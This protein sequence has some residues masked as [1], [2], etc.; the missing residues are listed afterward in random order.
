M[1]PDL[2]CDDVF[3]IETKR[4]WLRWPTLADMPAILRLAGEKQIAEMT[5]RIPHPYPPHEAESYIRAARA[6]NQ[7][8]NSL[9]MA[10][11]L[12]EKPDELLGMIGLSPARGA[13]PVLGYWIGRPYWGCGYATEAAQAMIDTAFTLAD[14]GSIAAAA[15]LINPASRGVL[16]KCGFQFEGQGMIDTPARGVVAV[17]TFRLSRRT[18]ESLKLWRAPSV[19]RLA[20]DAL[21]MEMLGTAAGADE[22][23]ACLG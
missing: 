6:D 21:T 11:T 14:I 7:A 5:A 1:F 15:R 17:D 2:T 8:G 10:V 18:F 3:R 16:E 12:K 19:P 20:I 9:V 13:A 23:Q 4:L 22:T